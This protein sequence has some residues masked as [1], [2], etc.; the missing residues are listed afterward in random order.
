MLDGYPKDYKQADAVFM[1]RPKA[2]EKKAP[3]LDED[4]NPIEAQ[5]EEDPEELAKRLKPTLHKHIFPE[6]VISLRATDQMLKRRAKATISNKAHGHEK[7]A[8][9]RLI[10]K[11]NKYNSVN[12]LSLFKQDQLDKGSVFPTAK[13]F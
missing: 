8:D 4:G 13:F 1:H 12:N 6:S 2:P 7:W 10:E 11:V 5:E 9:D 3:E